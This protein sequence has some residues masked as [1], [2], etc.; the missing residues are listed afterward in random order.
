MAEFSESDR[1][2]VEQILQ[3]RTR[4]TAA[5]GEEILALLLRDDGTLRVWGTIIGTSS[6]GETV[7]SLEDTGEQR[8]MN[9]GFNGTTLIRLLTEA[10]GTARSSLYGK[11][12]DGNVDPLRTND[13]QQLQVQ[14]VSSAMLMAQ[15]HNIQNVL[16]RVVAQLALIT[17]VTL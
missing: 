5:G 15:L 10:D 7:I 17:D 13:D 3:G 6:L 16:E 14:V 2:L 1:E 12:S 11:D 4:Q 9:L 8:V